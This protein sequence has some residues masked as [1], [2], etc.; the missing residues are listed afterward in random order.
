MTVLKLHFPT[1]II[2]VEGFEDILAFINK[3]LGIE[4]QFNNRSSW[5]RHIIRTYAILSNSN[6]RR[7]ESN[8]VITVDGKPAKRPDIKLWIPDPNISGSIGDLDDG[9]NGELIELNI[10]D[11]QYSYLKRAVEWE[12]TYLREIVK[13]NRIYHNVATLAQNIVLNRLLALWS[14]VDEERM[15]LEELEFRDEE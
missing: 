2:N 1:E 12:N 7:W 8:G 3:N 10:G 15:K 5:M 6:R 9:F 4:N 13:S 14:Q 11:L